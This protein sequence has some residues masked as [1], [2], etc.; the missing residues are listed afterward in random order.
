MQNRNTFLYK[1][2]FRK[3][4]DLPSKYRNLNLNFIRMID[5]RKMIYVLIFTFWVY[6]L[7]CSFVFWTFDLTSLNMWLRFLV[8]I[9]TLLPILV[10]AYIFSEH[11]DFFIKETH[12]EKVKSVKAYIWEL[13]E[14]LWF[15]KEASELQKKIKDYIDNK[16]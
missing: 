4:Y 2:L 1:R 3:R 10:S 11:N 15:Y 14:E 7:I 13:K 12:Q 9:F 8:I 16:K 6:Y 5:K